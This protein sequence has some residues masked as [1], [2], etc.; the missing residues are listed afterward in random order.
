[1]WRST[2]D[3]GQTVA[4]ADLVTD[5]N[6][7]AGDR[8]DLG[9]IDADVYADGN[10][11]FVFIGQDDF[12]GTPGEIRYEYV[13]N[14]TIIQLQTGVDADIEGVIRIAGIHMPTPGWFVL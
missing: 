7:L 5:F 13:G 12:S 8:I 6:A 9:R 4:T 1:V 10:Q 3:A 2:V 14:E 11:A